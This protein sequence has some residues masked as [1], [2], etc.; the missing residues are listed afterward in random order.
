MAQNPENP[1]QLGHILQMPN[2]QNLVMKLK[3][4]QDRQYSP[5]PRVFCSIVNSLTTP[6]K[7]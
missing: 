4:A 1:L 3:A 6:L 2:S 5:P 7:L